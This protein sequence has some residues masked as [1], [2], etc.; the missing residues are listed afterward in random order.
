MYWNKIYQLMSTIFL[1][2]TEEAELK[3]LKDYLNDRP[4]VGDKDD[5]L[6]G[7]L[8][9]ERRRRHTAE[10]DKIAI[11]YWRHGHGNSCCKEAHKSEDFEEIAPS[12]IYARKLG[13]DINRSGYIDLTNPGM[14]MELSNLISF[15][16][17]TGAYCVIDPFA[18]NLVARRQ[19]CP[20]LTKTASRIEALQ[21]TLSELAHDSD[22][23]IRAMAAQNPN[24]PVVD[25]QALLVDESDDVRA[26]A[27]ETFAKNKMYLVA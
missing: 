1:T 19:S 18:P 14:G 17:Q 23:S 22:P 24:T 25:M 27:R 16:V 9:P 8:L 10:T 6:R 21:S 7:D 12:N 15:V 13:T 11:S 20:S 3:R 4:D 2:G 26:K 5:Y